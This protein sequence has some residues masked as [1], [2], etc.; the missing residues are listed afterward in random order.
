MRVYSQ[1]AGTFT[2]ADNTH[3]EVSALPDVIECREA[4]VLP[5]GALWV[6]GET[7]PKR[8]RPNDVGE[9]VLAPS[10]WLQIEEKPGR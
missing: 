6:R 3:L 4:C 7:D 10:R 1:P 9:L 2:A 8:R 5:G